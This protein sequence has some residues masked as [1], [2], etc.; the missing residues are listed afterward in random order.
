M[1]RFVMGRSVMGRFVMAFPGGLAGALVVGAG[2]GVVP[3]CRDLVPARRR[4]F[5]DGSR[6]RGGSGARAGAVEEEPGSNGP[7]AGNF[8][9]PA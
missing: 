8:L 6:R 9:N 5:K 2:N 1:G 3:A 4:G 7:T